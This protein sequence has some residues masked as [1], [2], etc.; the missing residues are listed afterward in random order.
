MPKIP[1]YN[2]QSN[3]QVRQL[4]TQAPA[5]RID[6]SGLSKTYQALGDAGDALMDVGTKLY[7]LEAQSEVSKA[8][9]ATAKGM[10]DVLLNGQQDKDPNG[11]M[12]RRNKEIIDL[13]SNIFKSMKNPL[14]IKTFEAEF[15]KSSI[16]NDFKL[17]VLRNKLVIDASLA[18]FD[19]ERAALA[20][21]FY[22]AV[23][24]QEKDTIISTVAKRYSDLATNGAMTKQEAG[25]EFV[26]WKNGLIEGQVNFDIGNDMSTNLT[27]SYVY[28]QLKLGEKGEYAGL[29]KDKIGNMLQKIQVKVQ[30]NKRDFIFAQNTNQSQTLGNMII[31][32]AEG[33]LDYDQIKIEMLKGNLKPEDGDELIKK[34]NDLPA[35]ETDYNVYTQIRELQASGASANEINRKILENSDKLTPQDTKFLIDKTFSEKDSNRNMRIKFSVDAL[36]GWVQT[37]LS[38]MPEISSEIVY[39]F[40]NRVDSEKADGKRIDE[41]LMSVQKDYIKKYNPS[42]ALL[43]DV[44]NIIADRKRIQKV[45]EKESKIK[46]K[47]TPKQI[48]PVVISPG[49]DFDD[50]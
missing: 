10:N 20:E 19:I 41:I 4:T 50:L 46:A 24:P 44:P 16:D 49:I 40:F 27:D 21:K 39:D 23:S 30:R 28:N 18:N 12:E 2:S 8:S 13:R 45:Y 9:V 22:R 5:A 15:Q 48:T 14:A 36:K 6:S 37:N 38:L 26:K 31:S 34:I 47:S 35:V 43:E 7:K 42:T 29:E 3:V 33:T 25:Q 32:Q 1:T 17:K 11:F